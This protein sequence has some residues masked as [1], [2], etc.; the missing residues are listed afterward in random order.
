MLISGLPFSCKIKK[1]ISPRIIFVHI[2]T[3]FA[4]M[5]IDLLEHSLWLQNYPS[6]KVHHC[7]SLSLLNACRPKIIKSHSLS[8][9][10]Q[11]C[12]L[13]YFKSLP[14][15]LLEALIKF[16]CRHSDPDLDNFALL[17]I[18]DNLYLKKCMNWNL[19]ETQWTRQI[20]ALVSFVP[21]SF[22]EIN[23]DL[24]CLLQIKDYLFSE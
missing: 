11:L 4:I 23:W 17:K 22:W 12:K 7:P 21:E 8:L 15:S 20:P 14:N 3:F 16:L 5:W 2:V 13:F 6:T 24:K 10:L 19:D 18:Y 1:I 9:W